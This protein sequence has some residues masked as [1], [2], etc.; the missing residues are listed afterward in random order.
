MNFT[1]CATDKLQVHLK[2]KYRNVASLQIKKISIRVKF[3]ILR[4]EKVI[5]YLEKAG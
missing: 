4:L 5:F 1:Q 3:L 2:R